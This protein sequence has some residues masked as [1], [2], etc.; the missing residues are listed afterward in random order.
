MNK[1]AL[2]NHGSGAP[3][4][5]VADEVVF[6][7]AE[8]YYRYFRR[9]DKD[10]SE[11]KELKGHIVG[12]GFKLKNTIINKKNPSATKTFTSN[13]FGFTYYK[14]GK[15]IYVNK[16]E[17]KERTLVGSKTWAEWK[18]EAAGAAE[19]DRLKTVKCI[20]LYDIASD[21]I[22]RIEVGGFASTKLNDVL[23]RKDVPGLLATFKVS[24]DPVTH[25]YGESYV[26][27][28]DLSDVDLN[29]E[30]VKALQG[31]IDFVD[32]VLNGEPS[33]DAVD[34]IAAAATI[35]E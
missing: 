19:K 20:Y 8:G 18:E 33:A 7:P 35:F 24:A 14:N 2:P 31:K 23:K 4:Y 32:S 13:E 9:E 27:T 3:T 1:L 28:I 30:Q 34:A 29:A 5:I 12:I 26:P 16:F 6:K 22:M 10:I 21:K 25:D 15:K 11:Q 17:G